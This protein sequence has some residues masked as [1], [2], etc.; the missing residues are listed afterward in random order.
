MW[1]IS[2]HCSLKQYE[3][4]FHFLVQ[5]LWPG[6]VCRLDSK[7]VGI[8]LSHGMV[9]ARALLLSC[10]GSGWILEGNGSQ[11]VKE[12]SSTEELAA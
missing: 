3:Q 9:H 10:F 8:S 4:D 2:S 11:S 12:A 1:G 6:L 5:L 7:E